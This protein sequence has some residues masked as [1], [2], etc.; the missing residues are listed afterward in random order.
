[1]E[2]SCPWSFASSSP[3]WMSDA[4]IILLL[5]CQLSGK[6]HDLCVQWR[7]CMSQRVPKGHRLEP[8]PFWHLVSAPVILH[9][10]DSLWQHKGKCPFAV[11]VHSSCRTFAKVTL[12]VVPRCVNGGKH[13]NEGTFQ[14]KSNRSRIRRTTMYRDYWMS[15]L[16]RSVFIS[17]RRF[18]SI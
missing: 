10:P 14:G 2:S 18:S 13:R 1:M 16:L 3:L 12:M 15:R 7:L 11:I 6:C 17:D 9:S 5:C 4:I 8:V